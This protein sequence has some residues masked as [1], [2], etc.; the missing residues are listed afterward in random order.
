MTFSAVGRLFR[1]RP[2]TAWGVVGIMIA[3]AC[4]IESGLQ[5]DWINLLLVGIAILIIQGIIAHGVNDLADEEVDRIAPL[6]E[7]GRSKVLVSGE[8]SRECLF[9]ITSA[10]V[11]IVFMIII[12]L[13]MR[14]G[15]FVFIFAA[16]AAYAVF[17]YSCKP[18]KLGWHPF[19][20]L[21]VVVPT[22]TM[23][24]CG[25]MY[26]MTSGFTI[27]TLLVG[28][29]YGYF[30]ASWFM[31]SRAQDY[32]ADKAMGKMTTIV[33][34]G[35]DTT[36][37]LAVMYLF[38]GF[39]FALFAAVH[40]HLAAGVA[41]VAVYLMTAIIY[42]IEIKA[43]EKRLRPRPLPAGKRMHSSTPVKVSDAMVSRL[44]PEICAKLRVQGIRY[45]VIYGVFAA[46]T[47]IMEVTL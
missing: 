24:I 39:V 28:I 19:S 7:T 40:M 10:A 25:V 32:A 18:L 16:F 38:V 1:W 36:P 15:P 27:I 44:P 9:A 4:A 43:E 42:T 37:G 45:T 12:L 14:A 30:N 22:I 31:Y 20:E 34:F 23:L 41:L 46:F 11:I 29:S 8:M 6:E 3:V 2:V 17:G 47:I 13:A 21:T 5:I 26:V 35:L 33:H